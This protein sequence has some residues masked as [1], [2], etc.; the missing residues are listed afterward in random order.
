M[1]IDGYNISEA[2]LG[3]LDAPF[4]AKLTAQIPCLQALMLINCGWK[5]TKSSR[6][7]LYE[8]PQVPIKELYINNFQAAKGPVNSKLEVLRHFSRIECL[9]LSRLWLG[10]FNVDGGE[11]E[12]VHSAGE[13]SGGCDGEGTITTK[14][15]SPLNV[16]VKRLILSMADVCLNFLEH[17]RRQPF[18]ENLHSLRIR[19]L[20]DASYLENHE[21]LF[22]IGD[23]IRDRLCE[24]LADFHINLPRH[25]PRKYSYLFVLWH[26]S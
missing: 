21:D 4:M 23:I 12:D 25:G 8:E 13:D 14:S 19:D 2:S 7:Q 5:P 10:H 22:M 6:L 18:M 1:C 26:C 17:L 16:K 20:W 3:D 11:D 15:L 9:Y 24:N